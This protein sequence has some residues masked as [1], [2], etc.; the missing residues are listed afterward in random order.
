VGAGFSVTRHAT[1]QSYVVRGTWYGDITPSPPHPIIFY[2]LQPNP[3]L[4]KKLA[5]SSLSPQPIRTPS[6]RSFVSR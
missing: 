3:T 5:A 6:S 2:I 1:Q 4:V